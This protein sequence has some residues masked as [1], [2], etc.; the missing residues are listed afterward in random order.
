MIPADCVIVSNS[1]VTS[2][3][4]ALTGEPEDLK[5]SQLKD[6]FLLSSCLITEGEEC[7]AAIIGIG[8]NSQWGKIKANLVTESVNTPLQDKLERMTT[9]VRLITALCAL[10][11]AL[12][13]V[14]L[15]PS[16]LVSASQ[17]RL[18]TFQPYHKTYIVTIL[19][20]F[21]PLFPL[22]IVDRICRYCR[23]D[24]D[25]RRVDHQNMG[26]RSI[27]GTQPKSRRKGR[28]RCIYSS[29]HYCCSGDP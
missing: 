19:T 15:E 3:E 10:L 2:S 13:T 20:L 8:L 16:L 22:F 7:R 28:D 23:C 5:K 4:S 25:L 1:S 24:C 21:H 18:I 9:L 27:S 29:G 12:V 6:C 14:I 26:R 11:V 17:L